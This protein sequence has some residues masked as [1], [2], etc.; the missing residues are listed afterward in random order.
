MIL[1]D[2]HTN[3]LLKGFKYFYVDLNIYV[4]ISFQVRFYSACVYCYNWDSLMQVTRSERHRLK[5]QNGKWDFTKM[6]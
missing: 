2:S 1:T 3:S 4:E 6:S 5:S